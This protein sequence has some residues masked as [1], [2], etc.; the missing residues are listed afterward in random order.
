MIDLKKYLMIPFSDPAISN[1]ELKKFTEDHLGRMRR[2]N[3]QGGLL[4]KLTALIAATEPPFAAFVATLS[5][6]ETSGAVK[7][8]DTLAMTAAMKAFKDLVRRRASR[9]EDK[10]GKPSQQYEEFFPGGLSRYG[11]ANLEN[12]EQMMTHMVTTSTKYVAQVGQDMVTEF[13]AA[14]AAFLAA[15][16]GQNEQKGEVADAI[17]AREAARGALEIQLTRNLLFFAGEFLGEPE[18]LADVIDQS[19]L[20]EAASAE[21]PPPAP[22]PPPAPG[23]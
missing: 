14:K 21:E 11:A 7:E 4:G 9:V 3:Q 23:G 2:Q 5:S 13:T 18:R 22:T 20:K 6:R 16:G 19:I 8:G 17:R 1:G 15:R 10:F 12:V